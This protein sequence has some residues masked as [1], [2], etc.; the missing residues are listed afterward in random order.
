MQSDKKG[1]MNVILC[2][3][4]SQI[5]WE[6]NRWAD[7][8]WLFKFNLLKNKLVFKITVKLIEFSLSQ[9]K[10]QLALLYINLKILEDLTCYNFPAK[11]I[12]LE[13]KSLHSIENKT[14]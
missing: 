10:P 5:R 9:L 7:K 13:F 6:Y 1:K 8:V 11:L 3:I 4:V 2:G 14:I 12:N